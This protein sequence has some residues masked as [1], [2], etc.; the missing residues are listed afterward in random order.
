MY[1]FARAEDEIAYGQIRG[2]TVAL[3]VISGV[4]LLIFRSP[5][6][7]L[8]ALI[9]NAIPLGLIFGTL[10]GFGIPLDAGTALIGCL[11]LGVA[12]DDTIHIV[13]GFHE[14]TQT[15]SSA[16][17][18]L[19][20]TFAEVL[21]AIASTTAMIAGAFLVLGFSEFSITRNLG[22]VTSGIMVLCFVADATLL[23][24]LLLRRE[25]RAD[26]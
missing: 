14:R 2:L 24:A 23:P 16:R 10:G 4:L 22:L 1:E 17:S 3:L 18:A 12:V 19:D 7:A 25:Q 11:A 5:R 26:A 9:P 20:E 8:L 21:P 15:G 13:A 6:L